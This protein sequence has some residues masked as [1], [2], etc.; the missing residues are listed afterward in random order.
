[1]VFLHRSRPSPAR[2]ED[3]A[4]RLF[5]T[6]AAQ[7]VPGYLLVPLPRRKDRPAREA[8]RAIRFATLK[9]TGIASRDRQ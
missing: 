5:E 2:K 1:V 4:A 7:P 9:N 6:I 8:K 3:E